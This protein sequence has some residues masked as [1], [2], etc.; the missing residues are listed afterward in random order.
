MVYISRMNKKHKQSQDD[1]LNLI[2]L[3]QDYSDENKAR[4]LF[5]SWRW[6]N[7]PVCPHCKHDE[8]Y[9][10][11]SK[12][13]TKAKN[14]MR[15]GLYCCAACRKTF[16]ATVGTVFEDSHIP[17][18]KWLLAV[19]ILCSS[20]KSISANQLHRMLKV[21]YKTAWFMA[22]RIR[23]AMGPDS[24]PPKMLTGTVEVDETYI[25]PR[26]DIHHSKSSKDSVVALIQ[27][28]GPMH[29]RIVSNITHKNAGQMIRECVSKDAV[30]NTDQHGAYRGRFKDFKR[31]DVVNHSKFEYSRTNEDGTKSGINTCESFF[32]LFKRG[33]VGSWHHISREHLPKYANE[34]EFRWNTRKDTDGER[35]EKFLP[36]VE[37]RRLMYRK[38]L[39]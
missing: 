15:P 35:M 37:G 8:V 12:P 34:F 30:L 18:G 17:I 22:H 11:T 31:H 32:S 16:S 36:M 1:E 25:G 21:T 13:T 19:F 2:S 7:G 27:R 28:D 33:I 24:K 6:P 20:K 4:E 23:F 29:T 3:A 14:K 38:P 5:E 39:N 26:S 10:L 9:K